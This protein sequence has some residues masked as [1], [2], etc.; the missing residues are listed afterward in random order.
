MP[1]TDLNAP[2]PERRRRS[3]FALAPAI[4]TES[5]IARA[6][7]RMYRSLTTLERLAR[8]GSITPRQAEAGEHLRTDYELGIAGAR[9][10]AGNASATDWH[11]AEARLNAV[12]SFQAASTALGPLWSYVAPIAIGNP[13]MGECSISTLARSLGTNRQETAG[14]VKL[15]LNTL[16]DHYGLA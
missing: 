3:T 12:R 4:G 6:G 8:D 13:G 1:A 7:T 14:I 2:T 5:E 16:A 11:Y 10:H 9:N 15:G